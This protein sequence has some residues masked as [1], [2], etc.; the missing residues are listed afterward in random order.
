[1]PTQRVVATP[2][3]GPF[4][5]LQV[6]EL[7]LAEV[8]AGM[9]RVRVHASA[10][11]PADFGVPQGKKKFLHGRR[12]PM[13][14]GYDVSGVVEQVG[15]GVSAWKPGDEVFGMLHYGGRT[16]QGAFAE[17]VDAPVECL[18]RKP[19]QVSHAT[20][21]ASATVGMTALQALRDRGRLRAGGRVLI[22]GAAGGVGSVGIGVALKLGAKVTA[23]CST[24]AVELVR[25]LGVEAVLD[26]KTQDVLREARGPFDV[27]FD[28]A[29]AYSWKATRHLLGPGGAYV[30][31][32]P[33]VGLARDLL[34]SRLAGQRA[35]IVIVKPV[36]ADVALLAQWLAEGLQV[37]IDSTVP[38]KDVKKGILHQQQ[39]QVR[40]RI[41]VQ[42]LGGFD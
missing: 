9:V 20:A 7:P 29:A 22:L 37:P 21:A 16:T 39:G 36:A 31:T 5:Q 15:A 18:A 10:V 32:L 12:F 24:Y 41:A 13:V 17:W 14:M 34:W 23:V 2:S 33:S 35:A 4:E 40:G 19:A 3:Y 25:G 42:V 26:R 38:V 6:M 28:A 8:A 1:M 27:V 11:N 30:T